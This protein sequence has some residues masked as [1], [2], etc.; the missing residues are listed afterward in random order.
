MRRRDSLRLGALALLAAAL[1]PLPAFA[2]SGSLFLKQICGEMT[3]IA[4]MYG[5]ETNFVGVPNCV[6]L[7]KQALSVCEKNVKDAASCQLAFSSDWVTFD[8][9]VACAGLTG[10]D[11]RDCKASWNA[12]K[13]DWQASI[14]QNRGFGIIGC[15][16][17]DSICE[18]RCTGE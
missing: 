6:K 9:A 7:C 12:D 4:A 15:E 11:L 18:K 2:A 3:D 16:N 8:T 5:F 10:G 1:V 14:K 13:K 17:H